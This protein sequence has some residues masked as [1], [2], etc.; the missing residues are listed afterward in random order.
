MFQASLAPLKEM[1]VLIAEDDAM[2][3]A[4]LQKTL[5]LFFG[6]AITATDGREALDLY[7]RHCVD[8]AILDLMMPQ[9]SGLEVAAEIRRD[10]PDLP[11][12]IL[13]AY[14]DFENVSAAVRLRLME[15]LVKPVNMSQ[16]KETLRRCVEEM[17]QRG[18]LVTTLKSG[19]SYNSVT[20]EALFEGRTSILT[21]NEKL[22]LD[23]LLR[24]R[25]QVINA[26][27]IC[28]H[29]EDEGGMAP[30]SL[31]TLVYRLRGKIGNDAVVSIKD[32]GYMVP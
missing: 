15:Y 23:Y 19:A 20:G 32:L 18:R 17:N 31:R 24:R 16:L 10:D 21:R 9:F 3:R 30:G 2:A 26:P 29:L 11:I 5:Q 4:S 14:S 12:I 6:E 28:I 22:L 27:D 25:A 13:T 1:T 7:A 8:V